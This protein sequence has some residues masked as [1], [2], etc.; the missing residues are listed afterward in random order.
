MSSKWTKVLPLAPIAGLA[1]WDLLQKHHAV[2]RNFPVV[3]HARYLLEEIGPELRQYIVS[4]NDEERPFSRNQRR[5]IYAS[6][7]LENNYFGF[8]ADN[9]TEFTQGYPIIKHRT[10]SDIAPAT[11]V[12]HGVHGDVIPAAKVLGGHRERRGAF[13]P[14]SVVNVSAMS[15][16]SLSSA[17]IEAINR[18]AAQA[19]A[20]H[21]TGEGGLTPHHLHG[22][23]LTLQI[24]TAY[25]GCRDKAGRFDIAKLKD[26]V[27]AN[28][29][30]AIEIKLS[31]G[32]KPGLGGVLPVRGWYWTST[33]SGPRTTRAVRTRHR[34]HFS[35]ALTA[36]PRRR[37]IRRRWSEQ[38]GRNA[39][40]A[41]RAAARHSCRLDSGTA[42]HDSGVVIVIVGAKIA[43][44]IAST[45]T[46][47][48]SSSESAASIS[49]SSESAAS[50]KSPELYWAFGVSK[51]A[52]SFPA[53][54]RCAG[55]SGS[56]SGRSSPT[57]SRISWIVGIGRNSTRDSGKGPWVNPGMRAGSDGSML[58][59]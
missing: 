33:R 8:G 47:I 27:A 49:S 17:A 54:R 44:A 20:L 48:S 13:R 3:G 38:H 16:G 2:L 19:G 31:Q 18:G 29:V 15:F 25:F 39:D 55:S 22:A 7:K 45:C 40:S 52:N 58:T 37:R 11:Q 21:N 24:G 57:R 50:K 9:D 14:A 12:N 26:T 32:A 23:D 51:A 28:P 53:H 4:G 30:R 36:G 46:T 5:W 35:A 41:A 59:T 6:S 43:F 10:F 1:A 34:T 56:G 42:S